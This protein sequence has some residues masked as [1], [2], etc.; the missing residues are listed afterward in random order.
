MEKAQFNVYDRN[1]LARETY[2]KETAKL[3]CM[4]SPVAVSSVMEIE[5]AFIAG[6]ELTVKSALL[7]LM[8]M[9]SK[10]PEKLYEFYGFSSNAVTRLSA[11]PVMVP[12]G[13]LIA[14]SSDAARRAALELEGTVNQFNPDAQD[15]VN[16][17]GITELQYQLGT[18]YLI[19][20]A[21]AAF[22][23]TWNLEKVYPLLSTAVMRR[24]LS[25][26]IYD[27]LRED[28]EKL[29]T[30]MKETS[31][32]QLYPFIMNEQL[33]RQATKAAVSPIVA[34]N[35]QSAAEAAALS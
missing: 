14:K 11:E 22:D 27:L 24:V 21:L 18:F 26:T 13:D 20:G 16:Q 4:A 35:G 5:D 17:Y 25:M 12:V 9:F 19:A 7:H 30:F 2:F 32:G 31:I 10:K 29:N 28:N 33:A 1:T 3:Y 8:M 23:D 15:I 34:P 6:G